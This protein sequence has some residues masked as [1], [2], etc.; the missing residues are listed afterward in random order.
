MSFVC[1]RESPYHRGFF[2]LKKIREN[3]VRTVETVRNIEVSVPR[4]STVHV[5]ANVDLD[6]GEAYVVSYPE[7][8][9]DLNN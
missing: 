7:T 8:L 2:F 4:S 6:V 9:N 1:I 3:F 5:S